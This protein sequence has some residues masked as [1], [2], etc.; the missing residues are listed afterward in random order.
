MYIDSPDWI[1]FDQYLEDNWRLEEPVYI[2]QDMKKIIESDASLSATPIGPIDEH[3]A[4]EVFLHLIP[5]SFANSYIVNSFD[6]ADHI[7]KLLTDHK[8][9]HPNIIVYPYQ[10]QRYNYDLLSNCNPSILEALNEEKPI[11]A[12]LLID[13]FGGSF[14]S[15]KKCTELKPPV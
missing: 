5:P 1:E 3:I 15:G 2:T 9:P 12:N 7:Q 10:S 6:D 8:L 11:I 14:I 13:H 4:S